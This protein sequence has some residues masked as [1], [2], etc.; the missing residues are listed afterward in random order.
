[1]TPCRV[2]LS[3]ARWGVTPSLRDVEIDQELCRA[4]VLPIPLSR[5]RRLVFQSAHT[6]AKPTMKPVEVI[7]PKNSATTCVYIISYGAHASLIN[8]QP[9]MSRITRRP[10]SS[11]ASRFRSNNS[12]CRMTLES[13]TVRSA[14]PPMVLLSLCVGENSTRPSL[15]CIFA[16]VARGAL[17]SD[18]IHFIASLVHWQ[19]V[20]SIRGLVG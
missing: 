12:K 6:T 9:R 1:M 3:L 11:F 18:S 10:P 4:W 15:H 17:H 13:T 20:A 8:E 2:Q 16:G 7:S 5:T 14:L 19:G